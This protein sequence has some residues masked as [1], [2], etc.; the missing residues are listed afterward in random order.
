MLRPRTGSNQ[1]QDRHASGGALIT[2]A[3]L[4]RALLSD[5]SRRACY[6]LYRKV[7]PVTHEASVVH[8]PAG[9]ALAL[10][11][12]VAMAATAAAAAAPPLRLPRSESSCPRAAAARSF[13]TRR[14]G[15]AR[16]RVQPTRRTR[17][18]PGWA[19]AHTS[20]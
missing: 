8:T 6:M 17:T 18:L 2:G 12:A 7:R 5:A 3:A 4:L 16:A 9:D 10:S 15:S 11:A 13:A 1:T 20:C 14:R 19:T